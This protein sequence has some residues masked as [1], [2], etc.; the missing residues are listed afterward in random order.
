MTGTLL[1]IPPGMMTFLIV[2]IL[3]FSNAADTAKPA[4]ELTAAE[5]AMENDGFKPTEDQSCDG[6]LVENIE[7]EFLRVICQAKGDIKCAKALTLQ[8]K[9][10]GEQ[11][12][13]Q[14]TTMTQYTAKASSYGTTLAP[15]KTK[16]K[17]LALKARKSGSNGIFAK[18]LKRLR[19][20]LA[21]RMMKNRKAIRW[22]VI[23]RNKI[24]KTGGKLLNVVGKTAGIILA[25]AVEFLEIFG[26]VGTAAPLT[27][28][29]NC[30]AFTDAGIPTLYVGDTK[31]CTPY[32]DMGNKM[33][34]TFMESTRSAK[35]KTLQNRYTCKYYNNILSIMRK[36]NEA[37]AEEIDEIFKLRGEP[38]FTEN[39]ASFTLVA[40]RFPMKIQ[41]DTTSETQIHYEISSTG[42]TPT[43][44]KVN[45]NDQGDTMAPESVDFILQRSPGQE[46]DLISRTDDYESWIDSTILLDGFSARALHSLPTVI[47]KM[48]ACKET[49]SPAD[50]FSK[51]SLPQMADTSTDTDQNNE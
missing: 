24:A 40:G 13:Q 8:A 41:V 31:T 17:E 44:F 34:F 49:S 1:A 29:S 32:Y 27:S 16:F 20:G 47:G 39:K 22:T 28:E 50:C 21:E 45:T 7:N 51:P 11:L 30:K 18:G 14:H 9:M 43:I 23:A 12:K 15:Y 25:V 4:V 35:L 2:F 10:F 42:L 26:D 38:T 19:S 3:S 36:Q 33:V 48:L 6:T 5:Q 46:K 37:A